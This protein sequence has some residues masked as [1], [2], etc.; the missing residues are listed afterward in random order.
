METVKKAFEHTKPTFWDR[1]RLHHRRRV[2]YNR[3]RSEIMAMSTRELDELGLSREFAS[4][5]AYEE[6]QKVNFSDL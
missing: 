2:V 6:S 4:R 1:V 3:V 5:V